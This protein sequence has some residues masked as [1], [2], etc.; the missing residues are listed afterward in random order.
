MNDNDL[1]F[2]SQILKDYQE[3][4]RHIDLS[5]NLLSDSGAIGL[6]RLLRNCT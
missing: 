6:S 5:Y 4:I 2:L 1:I 3:L